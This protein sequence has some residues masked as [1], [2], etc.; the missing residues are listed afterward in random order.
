MIYKRFLTVCCLLFCMIGGI[1]AQQNERNAMKVVVFNNLTYVKPE[2]KKGVASVLGTIAD[3]L[4]TGQSTQQQTSYQEA[5]RATIVKGISQGH[6]INLMDGTGMSQANWYVDATVSNIST[7][8][9]IET[10][11]DKDGKERNKTWYKA[12]VGVTLHV[13]DAQTNQVLASPM[14]N[15]SDIDLTW[16]ETPEGAINSTFLK[17]SNRI[18]TYFDRWLP[19]HANIIEG[20]RDKKDKQKE[21]YIDLGNDTKGVYKGL[22]FGVYTAKIV[23]GKEAKKQIGRLK[24]TDI[25]GGEVSLCKVQSGGKDIKEAIDAGET[26]LVTSI[27]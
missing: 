11:K 23:A 27:E 17:L 5:L 15:I 10:Y 8:T 26:L 24:I 6:R 1:L 25:Q 19:L 7:T 12:L 14:F 4:L 21:V 16:I 18:T 13:K 22:R 3:V 20:A 2:Q 9:K